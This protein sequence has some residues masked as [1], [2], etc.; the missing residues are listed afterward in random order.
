VRTPLRSVPSTAAVVARSKSVPAA[1][2]AASKQKPVA[3]PVPAAPKG[4]TAVA[5]VTADVAQPQSPP[6]LLPS[7]SEQL[8]ETPSTVA[9][10]LPPKPF[11]PPVEVDDQLAGLNSPL[12]RARQLLASSPPVA[13]VT[14]M[15]PER[16]LSFKPVALLNRV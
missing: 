7:R 9:V 3:S 10:T 15:G 12:T 11:L 13:E 6:P 2:K 1:S 8:T 16:S 5:E 4:V 14:A